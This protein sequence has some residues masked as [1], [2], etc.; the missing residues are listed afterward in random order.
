MRLIALFLAFNVS[1]QIPID[2]QLHFSAGAISGTV[3][4]FSKKPLLTAISVSIIAGLAKETYDRHR[5]Y[6]FDNRDVAFTVAGGAF[7][8]TVVYYIRKKHRKRNK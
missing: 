6:K 4:V 5:G 8:G 1:A 7:T 2:K 3:S